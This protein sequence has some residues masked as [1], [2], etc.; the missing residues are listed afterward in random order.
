MTF[1]TGDLVRT[2]KE[3]EDFG[4]GMRSKGFEFEVEDYYDASDAEEGDD[5]QEPFVEGNYNGGFNNVTIAAADLELV[6]SA[7]EMAARELPTPKELGEYIGGA[8]HQGWSDGIRIDESDY[9]QPGIVEAYGQTGEGLP[10]GFEVVV[11][12]ILYTD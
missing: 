2:T 7:A 8:L 6:K 1:E 3:T 4:H 11:T 9:R 10:F 5:F 12:K